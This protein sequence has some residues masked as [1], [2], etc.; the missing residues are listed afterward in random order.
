MRFYGGLLASADPVMCT[1]EVLLVGVV[2]VTPAGAFM[3]QN[4][5]FAADL[6]YNFCAAVCAADLVAACGAVCSASAGASF[7]WFYAET[8]VFYAEMCLVKCLL[9]IFLQLP[10]GSVLYA[11]A[12][13][14]LAAYIDRAM[15]SLIPLSQSYFCLSVMEAKSS[16]KSATEE[17]NWLFA[18][19]A[20]LAAVTFCLLGLWCCQVLQCYPVFCAV[21]LRFQY[22]TYLL[23]ANSLLNG[24]AELP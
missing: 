6:C 1:L 8:V 17:S 24:G 2:G 16:A 20:L 15:V 3:L 12:S 22:R 23:L 19:Y 5:P 11:V 13:N 9:E 14:W 21:K 18:W 4:V 10:F 7:E